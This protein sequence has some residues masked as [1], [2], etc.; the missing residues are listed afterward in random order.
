METNDTVNATI[1]SIFLHKGL[2]IEPI[3]V[4]DVGEMTRLVL[5]NEQKVINCTT[6]QFIRK[7][8]RFLFLDLNSLQSSVKE[9]L[10]KTQLL[11]VPI[12]FDLV[13][14][15][16]RSA[17]IKDIKTRGFIWT[18]HRKVLKVQSSNTKNNQTEV[19][20]V[21][22]YR[23]VVPYSKAFVLQQMRD[24]QLVDFLFKEVH[25]PRGRTAITDAGTGSLSE[26]LL[27]LAEAIRRYT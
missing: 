19:Q 13:L 26:Q 10:H 8:C 22:G 5:E 6:Q 21:G 2:V 16:L 17:S 24:A 18:S 20:M 11:P 14:F 12:S 15:P 23:F 3:L 9:K 7:L 25:L 4:K 1:L 27:Y